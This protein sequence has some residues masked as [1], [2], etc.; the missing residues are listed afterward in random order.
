MA[1]MES[2]ESDLKS[3]GYIEHADSEALNQDGLKF[4]T[5]SFKLQLELA[6]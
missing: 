4:E 2:M 5:S 3:V 6:Y 1:E